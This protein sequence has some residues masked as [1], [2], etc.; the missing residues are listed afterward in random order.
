MDTPRAVRD[1]DPVL[2]P[3]SW[4]IVVLVFGALLAGGCGSSTSSRRFSRPLLPAQAVSAAVAD[5]PPPAATVTAR[6]FPPGAFQTLRPGTAVSSAD[7][8]QQVFADARHGFALASVYSGTYPAATVDGGKTWQIDGPF[9]PIPAS[10]APLAVR[11]PGVA[12]PTTY[13]ASGG[14][15]GITVVDATTDAGRHWWQALLPGGVVY[16]GAFEGELTAI[17][18]SPTWDVPGARVTFWVY[19]SRTGRR[20]TYAATVNSPS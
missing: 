2:G 1:T 7:L 3:G 20:W 12:G 9:L 4:R 16:V 14:Q 19:R 5:M 6:L 17:I 11:Y 13:F 18:A 15:G 10:T 8:G